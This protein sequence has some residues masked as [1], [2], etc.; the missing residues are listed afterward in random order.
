MRKTK[1]TKSKKFL[2]KCVLVF[3]MVL[4]AYSSSIVLFD[5][6]DADI[7]TEIQKTEENINELNA[8]IDGLSA[9]KN[10]KVSFENVIAVAKSKG[11][12][13]NYTNESVASVD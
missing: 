2:N 12:S 5:S 11:Y 7:N 13:L 9:A 3:V 10:E 4:F 6:I 8:K 1:I